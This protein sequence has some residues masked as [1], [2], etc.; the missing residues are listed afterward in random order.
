L[1]INT[2]LKK[3]DVNYLSFSDEVVCGALREVFAKNSVLEELTLH[4][5]RDYP[6]CSSL[7]DDADVASWCRTL[8]FLRDNKTLKS[9][10]MVVNGD[11]VEPHAT[12][13]CID[14]VASL[15]DNIS[16][17]CLDIISSL[18]LCLA[19]P[20]RFLVWLGSCYLF[21]LTLGF[22]SWSVSSSLSVSSWLSHVSGS[23]SLRLVPNRR[24]LAMFT[25]SSHS[26]FVVS[27]SV[28]LSA[29]LLLL[30]STIILLEFASIVRSLQG[31]KSK[32][33]C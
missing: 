26:D 5:D 9:F 17:E 16:L 1:S 18:S 6:Y 27:L 13:I 29:S 32:R 24:C 11:V 23:S 10:T 2:S 8:P 15:G 28:S 20:F 7:V 14:T 12:A 22:L 19:P 31:S 21:R 33:G 4:F 25:V 3:L 30:S